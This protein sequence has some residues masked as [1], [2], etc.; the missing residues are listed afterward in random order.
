MFYPGQA[1][2]IPSEDRLGI[3]LAHSLEKK[4]PYKPYMY[5]FTF[6]GED[7]SESYTQVYET[8]EL[9][10]ISKLDKKSMTGQSVYKTPF[11]NPAFSKM[12]SDEEAKE[13]K[14]K[15]LSEMDKILKSKWFKAAYK[16]NV[17]PK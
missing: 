12:F 8:S 3:F 7:G 1:V 11:Q 15:F 6:L 10:A 9:E 4:W 5:V 13:C 16:I 14:G 17:K 2:V